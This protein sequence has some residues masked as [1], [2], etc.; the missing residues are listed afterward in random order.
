MNFQE[1]RWFMASS[2]LRILHL[3]SISQGRLQGLLPQVSQVGGGV[4]RVF[5]GQ[6]F[7]SLR[8]QTRSGGGLS[9]IDKAAI[10]LVALMLDSGTIA[11]KHIFTEHLVCTQSDS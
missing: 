4:G 2:N 11:L 8:K 5:L 9:L 10:G 7:I 3:P 6:Y 1:G